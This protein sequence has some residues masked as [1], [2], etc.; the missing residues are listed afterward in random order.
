MPDKITEK[1]VIQI[2]TQDTNKNRYSF[3]LE[4]PRNAV[5]INDVREI[6]E[7]LIATNKWYSKNGNPINYIEQATL[8]K[9]KKIELGEDGQEITVTPSK[10]EVQR[11]YTRDYT[12][13]VTGS[14][15]KGYT[16][17]DVVNSDVN[18]TRFLN[19]SINPEANTITFTIHAVGQGGTP[20][21]STQ[22]T[23][24]TVYTTVTIDVEN[25]L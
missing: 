22:V 15:I 13:T 1:N 18:F 19:V 9:T 14:P 17:R 5:T 21:P 16:V 6:F 25:N 7:P 24:T 2:T 12:L 23:I 10:I 11:G 8:T 20:A 3:N 4:D